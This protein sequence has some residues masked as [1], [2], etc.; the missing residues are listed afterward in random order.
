MPSRIISPPM[1]GVP[2]LVTRCDFG[3]SARIGWP[4][5][6]RSRR[7]SMIHGPNMNTKTSA[8]IIEPA[9]AH[10]QVAEDVED[11]ERAGKIGQPIEHR[12][13]LER[14]PRRG[15]LAPRTGGVE[16]L[17]DR[18]HPRAERAL[19][20]HRVA[21]R[22]SRRAHRPRAPR[23]SRHSR[24]GARREGPPTAPAY[25][26]PAQNTRSIAVV[27]DRLGQA[28]M[29]L[30]ALRARAPACRRAP[31]CAGRAA[32]SAPGRAGRAPRAS[33]PDWRCSFRRSAAPRRRAV[34]ASIRAPRPPLGGCKC[35][36]RQRREREIGAGERRPP[37]APRANS[38]PHGGPARRACR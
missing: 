30:G 11:R 9:G 22:A 29:Q 34:R 27:H 28:A 14:T 12:I 19:D 2:A 21:R 31:R 7:W 24:P 20:H 18:P 16:R 33:R 3:P 13:N 38:A 8:V 32:R 6:C 23:T 35:G 26:G 25:S 5:P 15:R 1:V 10:R 17:D 4:L 37:P 36:E